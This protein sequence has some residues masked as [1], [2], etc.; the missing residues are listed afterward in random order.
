M[1]KSNGREW[2]IVL[3]RG[4]YH[5]QDDTGALAV[6]F[7]SVGHATEWAQRYALP[8]EFRKNPSPR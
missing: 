4:V 7:F 1:I 6:A 3:L 8:A 5:L 2:K